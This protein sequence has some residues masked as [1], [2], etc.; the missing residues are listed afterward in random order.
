MLWSDHLSRKPIFTPQ[1]DLIL[2]HPPTYC[3]NCFYSFA[4][5]SGMQQCFKNSS[6]VLGCVIAQNQHSFRSTMTFYNLWMFKSQSSWWCWISQWPLTMLI[7]LYSL[8]VW[9]IMLSSTGS[10]LTL[11]TG[12]FLWCSMITHLYLHCCHPRNNKA[13]FLSQLCF[14]SVCSPVEPSYQIIL[15]FPSVHRWLW[16][17]STDDHQLYDLQLYLR[18]ISCSISQWSLMVHQLWILHSSVSEIKLW[19][20]IS[21]LHLKESKTECFLFVPL[22][23]TS[24]S[25]LIHCWV[26]HSDSKK[27]VIFDSQMTLDR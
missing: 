5:F 7:I 16:A 6:L 22:I 25:G 27:T 18:M 20:S 15:V 13:P 21:F 19:L 10:A 4:T 9:L 8:L 24:M 14:H 26:C 12:P 2:D 11:W 3:L 1:F 17:L 23:C